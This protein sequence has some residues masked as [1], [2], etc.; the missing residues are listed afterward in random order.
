MFVIAQVRVWAEYTE[1]KRR[2]NATFEDELA[3]HIDPCRQTDC[4]EVEIATWRR[5][6]FFR[7]GKA[8][9]APADA[10]RFGAAEYLTLL[11]RFLDRPNRHSLIRC[12]VSWHITFL[13]AILAPAP[14]SLRMRHG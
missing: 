8:I 11:I 1:I 6:G 14:V 12:D 2:Y 3:V 5:H 7:K 4:F 9:P 10:F 13:L